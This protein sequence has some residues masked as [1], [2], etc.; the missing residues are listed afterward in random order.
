MKNIKL[1]FLLFFITLFVFEGVGCMNSDLKD[2]SQAA[3]SS[4]SIEQI[5]NNV[6]QHLSEKYDCQ[7]ECVGKSKPSVLDKTY[8]LS[9]VRTNRS[10]DEEGFNAY[11]LPE[12][13]EYRDNYWGIIARDKIDSIVMPLL[14]KNSKVFSEPTAAYYSEQ[15]N[16]ESSIEDAS[17]LSV[18]LY[19]FSDNNN[20]DADI[21]IETLRSKGITGII[22]FYS[23]ESSIVEDLDYSD[24]STTISSIAVGKI[25]AET[26]ETYFIE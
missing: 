26:Q 1:V 11:Y 7:F 12:E 15:L 4:V 20:F 23:L 5:E 2:N 21:V 17:P 13:N 10:Y 8:S 14:T 18:N 3:T 9:V 19:I 24:F 16:F 6:L 25:K 22:K